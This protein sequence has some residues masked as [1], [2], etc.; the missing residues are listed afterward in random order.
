MKTDSTSEAVNRK[1]LRRN[2]RIRWQLRAQA[3]FQFLAHFRD[4]HPRH[5][6]ELAAQHL[7][8]FVLIRQLAAHTAILAILVPTEASIRYRFRTD[9]LKSPQKRIPLRDL[10][11]LPENRDFCLTARIG[12]ASI[13]PIATNKLP[14]QSR[15]RVSHA[16]RRLAPAFPICHGGEIGASSPS[17]IY[18]PSPTHEVWPTAKVPFDTGRRRHHAG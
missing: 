7:V 12:S 14:T 18:F 4:I 11:L 6:D 10:K 17:N 1:N 3:P 8:R 13:W 16:Q 5:H 2:R 9:E 15:P